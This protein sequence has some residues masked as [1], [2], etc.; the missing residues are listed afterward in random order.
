MNE[1]NTASNVNGMPQ[2]RHSKLGQLPT[3]IFIWRIFPKC[4]PSR[5]VSTLA[6]NPFCG[7]NLSLLFNTLAYL[8]KVL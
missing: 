1:E 2:S 5:L 6:P 7:F 8:S 4:L 3:A